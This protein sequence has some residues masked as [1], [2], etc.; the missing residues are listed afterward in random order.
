LKEKSAR[1]KTTTTQTTLYKTYKFKPFFV[2]MR[3]VNILSG[4]GEGRMGEESGKRK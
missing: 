1:T 2:N 3:R 4:D